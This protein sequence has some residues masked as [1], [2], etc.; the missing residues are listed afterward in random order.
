MFA[1]KVKN[2]PPEQKQ[3]E[4]IMKNN[5]YNLGRMHILKQDQ[6]FVLQL[7]MEAIGEVDSNPDQSLVVTLTKFGQKDPE[8]IELAEM[9]DIS[10]QSISVHAACTIRP[11]DYRME[12]MWSRHGLQQVVGHRGS[13][14]TAYGIPEASNFQS[15][16]DQYPI[17]IEPNLKMVFSGMEPNADLNFVQLYA[18]TPHCHV[19]NTTKHPVSQIIATCGLHNPQHSQSL[20]KHAKDYVDYMRDLADKTKCRVY[21]RMEA[22]FLLKDNIPERIEAHDFYDEADIYALLQD[23]PM[24]LVFKD[25][26][27]KLGL[28]HVIH[29]VAECLT[30]SLFN[31]LTECKGQGGYMNSWTAFQVEL[32][33]EELF[34]GKPNNRASVPFSVSLGT[35]GTNPNSLTKRRAF[36]GL[37]PAESASVG[38]CPPPLST[39]FNDPVQQMRV[40][41]IFPLTD[42][43]KAPPLII[44]ESLVQVLLSD[45]H[46]RNN[47]IPIHSLKEQTPPLFGKLVGCRTVSNFS[48]DLVERDAFKYP[49]TFKRALQLEAAG[50]DVQQCLQLALSKLKYFPSIVFWDENRH[51][52][53]KWNKRDYIELYSQTE[54]PST[55]AQAAALMGDICANME[56]SNL[57]YAK[58]IQK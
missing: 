10:I 8:P 35:N 29:P 17:T 25:N 40:M 55:E 31:L 52:K 47:R 13:L 6:A 45:L 46:E 58:H 34:F 4:T 1:E 57:T 3:R 11:K 51:P 48:K 41:R 7:L 2:L 24:I 16:L 49:H 38:E 20:L 54:M 39:W 43:L 15:N 12:M 5:S 36:L 28:R 18:T 32:A 27:Q 33:L 14:F 23:F 26:Q 53:A 9:I 30:Q 44:G 22:V 19:G 42:S 56:R 21:T 37:S 50:Q